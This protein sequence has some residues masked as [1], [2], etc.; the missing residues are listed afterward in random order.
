[1]DCDVVRRTL[2]DGDRRVLRG[3]RLRGHL[4][5]CA[6]CQDFERALPRAPRGARGDGPAAAAAPARRC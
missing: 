2:S 1:M 6:G 4:R 3:M 5:A